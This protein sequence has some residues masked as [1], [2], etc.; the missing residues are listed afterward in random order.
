[1][2]MRKRKETAI[3]RIVSPEFTGPIDAERVH[4]T[5]C[6][7][8]SYR[9]VVFHRII[10]IYIFF[11]VVCGCLDWFSSVWNIKRNVEIYFAFCFG[12]KKNAEKQKTN[13]KRQQQY[14]RKTKH[15]SNCEH[16]QI[17]TYTLAQT[18]KHTHTYT[19]TELVFCKI[20]I[21]EISIEFVRHFYISYLVSFI[22]SNAFWIKLTPNDI[23][24]ATV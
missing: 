14:T 4:Q 1:M 9:R 2:W 19:H 24:Y 3:I 23:S 7:T 15:I 12:L 11:G 17:H 13:Q 10:K 20:E 6:T 18:H 21:R 8:N 16:T 22:F 5:V